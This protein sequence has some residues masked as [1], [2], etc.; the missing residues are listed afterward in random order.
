MSRR[1]IL[2][3]LPALF[4]AGSLAFFVLQGCD[5]GCGDTG[6]SGT[7]STTP[8][9]CPPSGTN[10]AGGFCVAVYDQTQDGVEVPHAQATVNGTWQDDSTTSAVGNIEQFN[11]NGQNVP[12]AW[13]QYCSGCRIFAQWDG[14]ETVTNET[15]SA[16][17]SQPQ[18]WGNEITTVQSTWPIFTCLLQTISG[19]F[20]LTGSLPT[21]LTLQSSGISSSGGPPQ[22]TVYAGNLALVSQSSAT[23]VDG[24][25]ATFTF[26]TSSGS[27]LP[28][29]HYPFTVANETSSGVYTNV[30]VGFFS[31]G[32][33]STSYTTPYGVD[34]ADISSATTE[35]KTTS[36]GSS[37]CGTTKNNT[38]VAVLTLASA[39]QMVGYNTPVS[40]GTEPVAVKVYDTTSQTTVHDEGSSTSISTTTTAPSQAI[41]ANFGSN[42]VSIV[43]LNTNAVT[44]TIPVGTEPA[45]IVLS[46]NQS[47]A[48]VANFGG[49]SISI[50]DLSS[51]T[52]TGAIAVGASPAALALDPSGTA[53]WVGGD[54]YISE[55]NLSTLTA[56][57]TTQVDGQVSSIACSSG[58]NALVYTVVSGNSITPEQAQLST[59]QFVASYATVSIPSSNFVANTTGATATPPNWFMVQGAL[60]TASYGNRYA[61]TGTPAGFAVL[62]LQTQ[63]TMLQGSAPSAVRGIATDPNQDVIFATAPDSNSVI[64]V[65][66]PGPPSS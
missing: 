41:V 56:E 5:S 24:T 54:N 12:Y 23:S 25:S 62:D 35:C 33:N 28:A 59:G 31:I 7:A 36:K 9:A 2:W 8:P 39:N 61:V 13:P 52:E 64:T 55:I 26:P 4:L 3:I 50:I 60:V 27:V 44:A 48:Y 20:F 1:L 57:S 16:C 66:F 11:F 22:L 47:T 38:E 49:S 58:E 10:P 51:D 21:T 15:N 43:N 65:P 40:V 34:A 14:T 32:S 46:S 42:N 19:S 45:A 63:T 37:T 17:S 6:C 30:A 29:G 18:Q 53:L